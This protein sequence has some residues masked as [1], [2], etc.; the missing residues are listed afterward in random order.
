[1][2]NVIHRLS[3]G[4]HVAVGNVAPDT[5]VSNKMR[6]RRLTNLSLFDEQ[7]HLLL[8]FVVASLP[9]SIE[10][11]GTCLFVVATVRYWEE[12]TV[13]GGVTSLSW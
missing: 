13:V 2:M 12:S 8:L 1:M 5:R 9:P 3:S 6:R 11:P 10:L 4:C 7:R